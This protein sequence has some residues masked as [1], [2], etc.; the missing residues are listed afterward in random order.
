MNTVIITEAP[1]SSCYE[2]GR[3]QRRASKPLSADA[4]QE[5]RLG[6]KYQ[7][8][9]IQ[10]QNLYSAARS[11]FDATTPTMREGYNFMQRCANSH[12]AIESRNQVLPQA[13]WQF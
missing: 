10:G 9:F 4:C 7:D 12:Y 5:T 3:K 6:W 8:E 13:A 2:F 11:I 1:P